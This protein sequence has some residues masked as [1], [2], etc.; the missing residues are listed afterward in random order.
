[1]N[2]YL[3]LIR[4]DKPIGTLLL[5]WPTLWALIIAYNGLPPFAILVT[6]VLG[7]FLT[8][9]AGCA[10]NDFADVKFDSAVSRTKDRPIV[11]GRVSKKE[12]I[13]I[14]FVFSFIAFC[15]ALFNLKFSTLIWSI[16]ALCLFITYPFFKR[17]FPIP[18]LY[19]GV[20]FS[21]GILMAFIEAASHLSLMAWIIF[22]AN[23]FWVLA[24]DTIYALVDIDDDLKI[25]MKTSAITFGSF[26]LPIIVFCYIIFFSLLLY[27]GF[28]LFANVYYYTGMLLV[29]YQ[30]CYVIYKIKLKERISCF[31]MFLYNN[32]IGIVITLLIMS[33]YMRAS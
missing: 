6:F 12:A 25:S 26:V 2:A 23:L 8:R 9:S 28:T 20:A 3:Q 10:V 19:L 14:T 5:L 32:N 17:F 1:M 24:Y 11:S 16:P 21:F 22:F 31:N 13:F 27:I 7:V 33:L 18:Q 15:L 4:F 29:L 30:I